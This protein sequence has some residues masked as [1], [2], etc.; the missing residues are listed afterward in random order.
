MDIWERLTVSDVKNIFTVPSQKGKQLNMQNRRHFGLTFCSDDG[1]ITYEM[2]GKTFVYRSE[3]DLPCAKE[4]WA[5]FAIDLNNDGIMEIV[6]YE[7]SLS[8]CG[9][10]HSQLPLTSQCIYK[11]RLSHIRTA[12]ESILGLFVHGTLAH[13]GIAYN[14][15][16]TLY[17][18]F[19]HYF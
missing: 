4:D 11:T 10:C 8:W 17:Q 15:P 16:R 2:N 9:R 3:A 6:V 7:K 12:N 18:G 14:K 19:I 1:Q 5:V 13:I